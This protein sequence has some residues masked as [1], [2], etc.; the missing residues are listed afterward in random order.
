MYNR[1]RRN[2][3]AVVRRELEFSFQNLPKAFDGFTILHIS[4]LHIDKVDGLAESVAAVLSPIQPDLCVLTGD[5]R[6][7]IRGS[8]AE[9]YPR[10][11]TVLANIRSRLGTYAILGNHD[12]A[13]IAYWLAAQNV[14]VLVNNAAAIERDGARLWILGTDDPFDYRCDDLPAAMSGVPA[15]EFKILLTHT[16]GLYRQAA[17]AG[18]HLYLCGHT[19]AGQIRLPYIGAIKKNGAFPKQF[20]QGK[21]QYRDMLAYTSW[22]AGCST[23]PVRFNCPPEVTLIR[24]RAA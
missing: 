7:E 19:H 2:A 8:C 18:I 3:V 22:G 1:G 9:V 15:D 23:V 10:M 24:L 11:R 14:N 16:P 20:A 6:Y 5:Y 21:W 17:D 4:D 12:A 13:E